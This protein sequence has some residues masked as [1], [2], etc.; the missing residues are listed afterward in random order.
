MALT[1]AKAQ[2]ER[3]EAVTPNIAA[4][5]LMALERLVSS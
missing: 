2:V 1:V 3:G 5:L 4:V